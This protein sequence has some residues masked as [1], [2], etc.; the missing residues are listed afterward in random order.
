MWREFF[1]LLNGLERL[2]PDALAKALG[3]GSLPGV[4]GGHPGY[5]LLKELEVDLDVN[6]R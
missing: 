1:R 3:G 5:R 6:S 2:R 4:R